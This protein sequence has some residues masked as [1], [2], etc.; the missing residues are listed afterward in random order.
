MPLFFICFIVF[1]LWLRVKMNRTNSESTLDS[2]SFW[3]REEK[4]NFTRSKDISALSYLTV[5][6]DE[7]P[8]SNSTEDEQEAWLEQEVKKFLNRKMINLSAF[9]NTDLK[10][11]YGIA[12][13]DELSEYDQNFLL[14]IRNLSTWG[15]YLYQKNDF[16]RAKQIMEYSLSIESD[17]S[18]V[19]TTLGHIYAAEGKLQKIDELITLAENSEAA[20]KD[21]IIR[22][23][24][25]CKLE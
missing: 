11:Q 17:I 6:E 25:L 23:L 19:Y 12:N 2:E 13:L 5:S 16:T 7:L 21:S 24:Q 20:L 10:E 4:A 18:T 1:V 8:F 15:N 3:E 14:F 9:S 22:Q